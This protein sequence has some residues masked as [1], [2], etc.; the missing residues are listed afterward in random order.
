MSIFRIFILLMSTSI[1]VNADTEICKSI[2]G[3]GT[4]D[5]SDTYTDSERF[6]LSQHV[7]C[8]SSTSTYASAKNSETSLGI[9]ITETLSAAFGK[10]VGENNFNEARNKFC[11]LDY[12]TASSSYYLFQKIRS[13]SSR[14][15]RSFNDCVTE[16]IRKQGFFGYVTQSRDKRAFSINLTYRSNADVDYKLLDISSRPGKLECD[17]A[18]HLAS[19]EQPLELKGSVTLLCEPSDPDQTFLIA[20]NTDKGDVT[21][22]DGEPIELV[23]RLETLRDLQSRLTAVESK[24]TPRNQVAFFNHEECPQGWSR[25]HKADGRYVLGQ[26]E[27]G[28]LEAVVGSPLSDKENR[29]VGKHQ[30][31]FEDTTFAHPN[32]WSGV[33]P[34]PDGNGLRTEWRHDSGVKRGRIGTKTSFTGKVEGTN[35][36]YI[37]LL[38]CIKN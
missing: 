12:T 2:V 28:E 11:Q 5:S 7:L 15:S 13:A 16:V 6:K 34:G 36:P 21:G 38:A 20:I 1:S 25:Y 37:Q 19:P 27:N 4:F 23:G 14:I 30:H 17:R 32:G 24:V 29:V 3:Y 35:S 9:P 26:Q 22:P 31:N 18:A 33:S 8:S 10:N